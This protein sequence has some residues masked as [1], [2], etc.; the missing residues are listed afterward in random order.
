MA[1]YRAK[2][3]SEV[4]TI[5]DSFEGLVFFAIK[6]KVSLQTTG[7]ATQLLKLKDQ[8]QYLV[9]L[10]ETIE[11]A[12]TQEA[13]QAIQELDFGKDTRSINRCIQKRM[14][15]TTFLK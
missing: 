9:K 8:Y 3:L 12:N 5:V 10:I 13:V 1:L 6:A 4:K 11:S 7:L 14:Q 15:S 2:N